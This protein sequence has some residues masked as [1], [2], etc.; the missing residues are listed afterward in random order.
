M[1]LK[2]SLIRL[3]NKIFHGINFLRNI[4]T[5]LFCLFIYL[6]FIHLIIVL[7]F[8]IFYFKELNSLIS[9]I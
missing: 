6:Y 7:F 1:G 4:K 8:I 9:N 2:N 5:F 3:T